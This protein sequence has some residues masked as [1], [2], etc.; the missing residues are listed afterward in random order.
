MA[1]GCCRA[2]PRGA[3]PRAQ[4]QLQLLRQRDVRR[5]GGV[6]APCASRALARR[7]PCERARGVRC[8]ASGQLS[9]QLASTLPLVLEGVSPLQQDLGAAFL[10]AAGALLVVKTC[11]KL[12]QK[13][14]LDRVRGGTHAHAR[15]PQRAGVACMRCAAAASGA[16]CATH[17]VNA[18]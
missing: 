5:V 8:T 14:V 2:A 11:D 3:A 17:T 4:P 9:S 7:A 6:T 15:L 13:N 18:S 16:A 1:I 10:A 12:A